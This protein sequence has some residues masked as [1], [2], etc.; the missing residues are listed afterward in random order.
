MKL[1][2]YRLIKKFNHWATPIYDNLP[3][4]FFPEPHLRFKAYC[5]GLPKT[6]TVS[7]HIMFNK[8][9]KSAHEPEARFLTSKILAFN[10]GK[11]DE[12]K[13]IDYV[14]HRDRRLGLEMDSSNLN[15]YLLP[16]LVNEFSNA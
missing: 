13:F 1:E 5:V 2:D 4:W 12:K 11:M 6:G 7:M 8:N 16:V 10:N 15:Y 14:K 3:S 9:F